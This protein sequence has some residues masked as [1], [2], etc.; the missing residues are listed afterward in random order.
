MDIGEQKRVIIVEPEPIQ[1]PV[2]EPAGP[3]AVPEP[4]PVREAEPVPVRR[5]GA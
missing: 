3:A 1:V 4:A 2:E 5:R